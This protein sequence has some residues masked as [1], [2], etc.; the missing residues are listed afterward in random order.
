MLR[1]QIVAMAAHRLGVEEAD[2]ELARLAG[3]RP[4]RSRRRA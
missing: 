4:R 3:Q 1:K 2:I